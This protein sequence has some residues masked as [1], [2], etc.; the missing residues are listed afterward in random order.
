MGGGITGFTQANDSDLHRSLKVLSRNEETDLMLKMLSVC[1]SKVPA[2]KREDIIKMLISAWK[3]T[4]IDFV[5]VFKKCFVTNALDGSEDHLV[6]NKLFA[7]TANAMFDFRKKAVTISSF[8]QF[9][10]SH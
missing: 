7:F 5:A 2:P 10:N 3:N 1:N 4:K 8:Y 9:V 6:S